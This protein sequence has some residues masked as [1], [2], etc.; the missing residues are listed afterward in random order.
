MARVADEIYL[1]RRIYYKSLLSFTRKQLEKLSRDMDKLYSKIRKDLDKL[2]V[3][4]TKIDNLVFHIPGKSIIVKGQHRMTVTKAL[5]EIT[6][7]QG[8]SC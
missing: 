3:I 7:A 6:N 1:G 8:H 4:R 5:Q 2:M